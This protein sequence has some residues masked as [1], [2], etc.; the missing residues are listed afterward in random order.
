MI[1]NLL[2][3]PTS[4]SNTPVDDK[5]E[6]QICD[7]FTLRIKT[8]IYIQ[9]SIFSLNEILIFKHISKTRTDNYFN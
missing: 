1:T 3:V 2:T 9:V 8:E 6:K 5:K 7:P 4:T